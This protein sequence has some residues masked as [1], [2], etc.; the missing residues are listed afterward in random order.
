MRENNLLKMNLPKT[1]ERKQYYMSYPY[2]GGVDV[3]PHDVEIMIK[4]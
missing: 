3:A 2:F 4:D 1:K